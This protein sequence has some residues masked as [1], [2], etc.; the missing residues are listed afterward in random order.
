VVLC[1]NTHYPNQALVR[2]ARE[3]INRPD[4]LQLVF[5]AYKANPGATDKLALVQKELDDIKD[6]MRRNMSEIVAR[7]QNLDDL[8]DKTDELTKDVI[9]FEREAR[10]LNKK[11][12]LIL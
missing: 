10:G 2:V 5:D 7:G 12:C 3:V 1:A 6:I 4:E 11:C 9:K 8:R